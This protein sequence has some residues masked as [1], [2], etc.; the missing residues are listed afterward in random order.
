MNGLTAELWPKIIKAPTII[1][2]KIIGV[3]HQAF[4]TFKKSHNSPS[5]DLFFDMSMQKEKGFINLIL[6]S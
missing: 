2:I 6:F 3:S 1:S 4:L 5:K